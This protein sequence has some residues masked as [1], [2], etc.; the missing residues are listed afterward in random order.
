M[1]QGVIDEQPQE[2]TT[3]P[4]RKVGD[5]VFVLIRGITFTEHQPFTMETILDFITDLVTEP[6]N[7]SGST[8]LGL[9]L[10]TSRSN[11]FRFT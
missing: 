9:N 7:Q 6:F 10:V 5:F 1:D 8:G 4:G 2:Y 3:T 11:G